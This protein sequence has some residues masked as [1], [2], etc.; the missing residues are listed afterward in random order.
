MKPSK[1]HTNR[2]WHNW[3]VYDLI[4]KSLDKYSKHFKG[5]IVDLG[6]GEAFFKS[7][8]LNFLP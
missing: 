5:H 8:Y 4:D 1:F 3:I 6:C 7:Y 2:R